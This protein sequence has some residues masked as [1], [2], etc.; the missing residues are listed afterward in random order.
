[1]AEL[2]GRAEAVEALARFTQQVPVG[3]V[4]L[5]IEGE[6]GIGKT[7]VWLEA[8]RMAGERG[9]HVLSARP[10]EAEA[11]L[12]FAALGDLVGGVLDDVRHALPPPQRMA[13]DVALL[14]ADTDVVAD[15]LTTAAAF[16]SVLTMLSSRSP[17][18]IAIDDAQWLDRASR[19]VLE[20]SARRLPRLSGIVVAHRAG[21]G[22]STPLGLD[23][24][25]AQG[26]LETLQLGPLSV[27]ELDRIVRFQLGARPSWPLLVR[28]AEAARG[29]PFFAIEISRAMAQARSAPALGDFLPVPNRLRDLLSDRVDRLSPAALAAVSAASALSHPTATSVAAALGQ[30][31]DADE[32]LHEAEQAGVLV[33]DGDRLSFSHPLLASAVYGAVTG[34]R[35]RA[36][37]RRLAGIVR[38]PEEA[39]RH[40]A[41]SGIAADDR[42]ASR[43]EQAAELA[44]RRGA[45][46]AAAELFEAACRLTP[47]EHAED[48]ARRMLGG[49]E[50]L[51]RAG[52]MDGARSLAKRALETAPTGSLRARALLVLGSIATYM[53]STEVR[54]G[55]QERALVEAGDDGRLRVEILLALFEGIALDPEQAGQ[56]ADEAIEL[57][58]RRDDPA[59][60]AQALA[61]KFIAEAVLG[62]GARPALL[63]EALALGTRSTYPLL[64]Y[65]WI[66]DLEGAREQHAARDREFRDRG[67]LVGAAELV[68]FLAMA[69]FRAG[70]WTAAEGALEE[71]CGMLVPF[72]PRGPF[73][74]SFADRSII[75]AHRGRSERAR[76]TLLDILDGADPLEVFWR[77]VCHSAQGVVEFCDGDYEAADRAWGAMREEAQV[78]GWL[79]FLDDRSEPDHVEAL[80][81]LGRLDDARRV[82]DHLEWRGRTLPRPWI[83]AGLPRARALVLAVEGDLAAALAVIDAAPEIRELPFEHGR[84]L[85]VRSQIE[86]R[87]NRRLAARNSLTEALA[88]FKQL[89]SPPWIA[90][91][92]ADIERL[93]LRHRARNEL[94]EGER[95]IAELAA[96]G[97]TNRQVAE[98]AFVSPKTVESN[99]ARVYQKLDIRSRAELGARMAADSR[100][101]DPES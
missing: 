75:D 12:S 50:A 38:D 67:D 31:L 89:G 72:G 87:A 81:G 51:S 78:V 60:L 1:M 77:M 28:V 101:A 66:D 21:E 2:I 74:A 93:G 46:E 43:I 16:L 20:Y 90:R 32:A 11:E 36:L 10:A 83:D 53:D 40:L 71:A 95:R 63:E 26:S 58:R 91:T 30:D 17:L 22:V 45:P 23:R 47:S 62:R 70:N 3:P 24:A 6:P 79:D 33:V 7:T 49:A 8:V 37:H 64:W 98:A 80:V 85:V 99:L 9:Y 76:S 29:N 18:V 97:L 39:A 25:L 68:E 41:R 15:P 54:L 48:L 44:E 61:H 56:R 19:R 100:S 96:A 55:Y 82:L 73:V 88:V 69:E 92:Q 59:R 65:H 34:T 13:L 57:L 27:S 94:T 84:L 86:R 52:D 35:R 4:G 14:R 5:V 42:A